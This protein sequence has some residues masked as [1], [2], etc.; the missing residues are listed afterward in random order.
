VASDSHVS[1]GTEGAE[2]IRKRT[3][4]SQCKRQIEPSILMD[5]RARTESGK[6]ERLV[7]HTDTAALRIVVHEDPLLQ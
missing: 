7:F 3:E 1:S 6:V 4:A 5:E 2:D